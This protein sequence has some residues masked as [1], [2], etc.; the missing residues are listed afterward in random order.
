MPASATVPADAM[1]RAAERAA[2]ATTLDAAAR[3]TAAM[4]VS[5]GQCHTAAG[6][7]PST[8]MPPIAPPAYGAVGHMLDHRRAVDWLMEGLII[9]SSASWRAG[10]ELLKTAPL[11][12]G[13]LPRDAA[14]T[15]SIVRAE[16]S[17]HRWAE[18][19]ATL[20]DPSERARHYAQLVTTCAQCHRAHA[21]VWG[22]AR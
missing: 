1:H 13:D 21:Q 11:R 10:A 7:M 6:V 16:K 17:L 19:A 15:R 22:P 5:C 20:T 4:F 14:L 18:S 9:P 3:E 8:P 2:A 12:R